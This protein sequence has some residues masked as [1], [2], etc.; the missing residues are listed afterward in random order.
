[1]SLV[2][3]LNPDDPM[4]GFENA[5]QHQLLAP[6]GSVLDP[7]APRES[8]WRSDHQFAHDDMMQPPPGHPIFGEAGGFPSAQ[9]FEDI[10]WTD[11]EARAWWTW[12]HHQEHQQAL[13][14]SHVSTFSSR[15]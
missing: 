9:N 7:D 10:D 2:T 5:Q 6:P 4:I 8:W 1:M 14:T 13:A 3:L 11:P 15:R 12:T